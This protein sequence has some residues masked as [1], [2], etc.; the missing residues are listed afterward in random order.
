[1]NTHDRVL[2][3]EKLDDWVSPEEAW[4]YLRISRSTIYAL[5]RCGDIPYK[6]LGRLIR[7]PKECLKPGLT[8][9]QLF[10]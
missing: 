2:R 4:R 9:D 8:Y 10:R 6:R 5:I 1:M 3:F 7:I